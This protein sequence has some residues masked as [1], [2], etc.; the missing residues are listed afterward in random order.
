MSLTRKSA[1]AVLVPL[2]LVTG[3]VQVP[4]APQ[5]SQLEIRQAQTREFETTD[6]RR[7]MKAVLDALQDRGFITK[8]AVVELGLITA[9]K[10]ND[11][12]DFSSRMWSSALMGEHAQW[13][14]AAV[15]DAT[16]NVSNFGRYTRVRA[17]FQRKVL[18][19]RGYIVT[20]EEIADPGFYQDFFATIDKSIF[21]QRQRI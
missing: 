5:R 18:D 16:I 13:R 8:N 17:S 20:I 3:C 4:P 14:K 10:E 7:V 6:D 12:E 1:A 19:N 15:V 9:A 11:V 21:I 2:L